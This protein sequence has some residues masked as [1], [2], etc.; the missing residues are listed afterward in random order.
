MKVVNNAKFF[1]LI[2]I[3]MFVSVLINGCLEEPDQGPPIVTILNPAQNELVTGIVPIVVTASDESNLETVKILVD[4]Q[5]VHTD[6]AKTTSFNWDTGPV[7]DNRDHHI[8]AYAIDEDENVGPAAITTVRVSKGT[9]PD[10][11]APVLNVLYPNPGGGNAFSVAVIDTLTVVA[12]A[13]DDVGVAGVRFFIDGFFQA[14][15]TQ[16]P[17][18]FNW[19]L[20]SVVTN[21]DHTIYVKAVDEAGNSTAILIPVQINP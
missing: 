7:A 3:A 13:T 9:S 15:D 8:A 11:L 4:G 1:S 21:L 5:V 2:A 20:T 19:D 16:E 6:D 14:E 10:T 12:E 17:Y 18:Q